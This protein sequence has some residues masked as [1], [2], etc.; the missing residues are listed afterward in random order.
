[1]VSFIWI[2]VLVIVVVGGIKL[3]T[4][5]NRNPRNG[6]GGNG[7]AN[8]NTD[9]TAAPTPGAVP[10]R[11]ST[12]ETG[13]VVYFANNPH[14]LSDKEYQF[15]YRLVGN[16]WRAYILRMPSLNGRSPSGLLTHRLFDNGQPYIC[17][18]KAVSS[19]KDIQTISRIWANNIQE[20]IATGTRFG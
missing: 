2:I 11:I 15:N 5:A 12:T 4:L 6:R 16:S 10:G 13:P 9:R 19:L 3:I 14:N 20:Y 7:A 8:G 18:D 1:M 17:W